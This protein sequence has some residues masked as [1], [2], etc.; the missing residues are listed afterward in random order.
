MDSDDIM[1][2]NRIQT[3][4]NFMKNTPDCVICGSGITIFRNDSI[5][6]PN[7]KLIQMNKLHNY[8]FTWDDFLKTRSTWFLNHPT[9]CLRKSAILKVGNYT[10]YDIDETK[11]SKKILNA[12]H[13][14][15]FELRMLKTFGKIYSLPD[16][17]LFY[18]VH[19]NQATIQ[20]TLNSPKYL[21]LQNKIIERLIHL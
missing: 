17:L 10:M 13:D 16:I 3:Q 21:E 11:Y 6:D 18:R 1:T 20:T 19:Q 4:L 5:L 12:I 8:E 7:S 9:T 15:D 2:I 14:Y